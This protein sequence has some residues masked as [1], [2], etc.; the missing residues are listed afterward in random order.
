MSLILCT[1]YDGWRRRQSGNRLTEMEYS[2]PGLVLEYGVESK[3]SVLVYRHKGPEWA[4]WMSQHKRRA[5]NC[6]AE[7]SILIL[8]TWM[9]NSYV[10]QS[11]GGKKGNRCNFVMPCSTS[12]SVLQQKYST[13]CV[14][15]M[16]YPKKFSPSI[17]H[18]VSYVSLILT[19]AYINSNLQQA[20]HQSNMPPAKCMKP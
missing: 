7:I 12:W 20:V 13:W 8:I 9:T 6:H 19:V 17:S 18:R 4:E 10:I 5:V 15:L 11:A 16:C 1:L 14:I 2:S 3:S